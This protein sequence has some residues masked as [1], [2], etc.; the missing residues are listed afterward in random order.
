MK[1]VACI[2]CVPHA[3][4][5]NFDG[6]TILRENVV[7]EI[8][9]A[10]MFAIEEAVRIKERL[11]AECFGLSMGVLSVKDTLR[12]AIAMGLDDVYLLSDK[13]FSGSDTFA[14][15]YI[16]SRAIR[17]IGDIDL[18]ICGR[19]SSDGDTGQ[20]PHE[21]ASQLG[22][23]CLINVVKVQV[24][25]NKAVCTVLSERGYSRFDLE[26]PAVISVLKCINEPR[27]PTIQR[28]LNSQT[29]NCKIL[30][31]K[32]LALDKN[33]CG[34]AGS[35]TRV[36]K[37]RKYSVDKKCTI[38]ISNDFQSQVCKLIETEYTQ[39]TGRISTK[40]AIP[41]K[42]ESHNAHEIWV[43]CE[44]SGDTILEV[45]KQL[46][47]KA[48]TLSGKSGQ[49]VSAV[50]FSDH[51]N[52]LKEIAIA[53]ASKIYCPFQKTPDH[54][55]DEKM[56]WAFVSACLRYSPGIVLFGS[57]T[58]G[59]WLAPFAASKLST[60]LTADCLALEIDKEGRLIQTRI[61]FGGNIIVD[62]VCPNS[63]PQMATIRQNVFSA[64]LTF[65]PQCQLIDIGDMFTGRNRINQVSREIESAGNTRLF[66]CDIIVAGGRGL[67][68]RENFIVLFELARLIGGTVAATRYAVDAG[69]IDYSYQI[70]Q[71]GV[72]VRPR[73]YLA[74]GISGAT[75][76]IIGMRDSDCI[77]SINTDLHAPIFDISDYKIVEDCN[78]VLS[79]LIN[80]FRT[81]NSKGETL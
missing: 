67:G 21:V 23:P 43:V 11:G 5:Q 1:A 6:V 45:S 17:H 37:I 2:K 32:L 44:Y 16:L 76:H 65:E 79:T 15:S 73:L 3:I 34:I 31:D 72:T 30:D 7:M 74:F 69:W 33:K 51:N 55:F 50:V 26:L 29:Y 62:I 66:D 24:F 64:N 41:Q 38:N 19:Q 58:W 36:K 9:P 42:A 70:G 12:K 53:G 18:V 13:L 78:L 77:L 28:L 14:T 10:D 80:K 35:P 60:G 49:N 59:R 52:V 22:I 25:A 81:F 39:K 75:E 48:R 4:E 27:I 63:I 46:L 8:S 68:S 47:S 61:A 71:T 20:V 40:S 56:L 57:T 54:M